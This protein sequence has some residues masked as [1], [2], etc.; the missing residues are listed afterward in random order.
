MSGT[1]VL[2]NGHHYN[3]NIAKKPSE[4]DMWKKDS[5]RPKIELKQPSLSPSAADGC[6]DTIPFSSAN[7]NGHGPSNKNNYKRVFF[8][9]KR[10]IYWCCFILLVVLA[11]GTRLYKLD[12]PKHVCWDETHFGKMGSYYINRT[13]FFDV[14]PPLGK[15]LIGLSGL[16]SGY[17]GK[18]S[19]EKPGIKYGETEYIGMRLFCSLLGSSIILLCFG[20]VWEMTQSLS[21]SVLS[22]FIIIFDTGCLTLSQYILL[23]PILLFFIVMSMY[24]AQKFKGHSKLPFSFGW[25]FWMANTGIFLAF[26]FSVKWVGL[27]II[28]LIGIITISDLWH[29]LGNLALSKIQIAKH[30]C[31]RVSCLIV[32]PIICYLAIFFVHFKVLSHSGT[33][34]GFFSS[35]FQSR[36]KGNNLYEANM[37]E[38]LAYG[39]VI[40]LKNHRAAGGLL[41]SHW[42]LYPEGVGAR[43]QQVTAYTHKDD[44][45][46]WLVKKFDRDPSEH[47]D[48]TYVHHGDVVR[49]EHLAT[50][51]NLHSHMESAPITKRHQQVSCYGI[52]GTGDL[53]DIWRVDILGGKLGDRVKTVRTRLRLIHHTT[54]CALYSHSKQLPKWGW[55]QMEVT[56]NPRKRDSKNIWNV[57][58]H[59]NAKL[60][61]ISFELFA[62]SFLE[63]V[64]E[65]HIVMAQSNSGLKPKE[66]EITSRPWQWPINYRG[67]RFS[68][69]NETEERVYLLGNPVLWWGNLCCLG[70]F[71]F[72][73]A[74]WS[75]RLQRGCCTGVDTDNNAMISCAWLFLGWCLHYLPFFCM[76]RV[77]YF[78]HYFPAMLFNSMLS[79]ILIDHIVTS[80]HNKLELNFPFNGKICTHAVICSVMVYS[81]H[82]FSPLSYGMNGPY[83]GKANSRLTHL[84]WLDSWEI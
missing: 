10:F 76:G 16:L 57:E 32:L 26:S 44:N 25:W 51:R 59:Y 64:L 23:D 77:L 84:K 14:H 39:S 15:M 38:D 50:Q 73:F 79:G 68:G 71:L 31:A 11:F 40:T 12:E 80:V 58:D 70:L 78:H 34:D 61:N 24:S 22:A 56:C 82:L 27:F 8:D 21:A 46:K 19:F 6:P 72:C 62:P 7:F 74:I 83:A 17:D 81:F 35:S 75:I 49:L 36:L 67:Q 4:I 47:D 2:N 52:N 18:F 55:E 45:N 29:L 13:F 1:I 42:H 41:H 43:Q 48:I 20:I 54:G 60:P 66:G 65:S 33:G 37:P 69:V 9:K 28:L 3:E 63:S 5:S 30:I 53:N